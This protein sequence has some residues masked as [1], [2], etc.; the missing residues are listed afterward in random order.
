M[1]VSTEDVKKLR[2]QTGAGVMDCKAALV[3]ANGDFDDAVAILRKR[4]IEVAA[5]REAKAAAEGVVCAYVHAGDQVGVLVEVNCETDFVARTD[6]FKGFAKEVA[7]QVAAQ[8]PLWVS[9]EDV[10]EEA[11]ARERDILTE[12]AQAEGKPDHIVEQMVTGRL[13]KFYAQNCLLHQPYIR[14]DSIT[15]EDLLNDLV[16]KTGEKVVV[17]RFVRYQVGEELA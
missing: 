1:A 16:A 7:L 8:Q 4:G 9:S 11:V 17:R 5:K 6:D 15:V 10:P 3:E 12:Q 14:D 13:K 2:E